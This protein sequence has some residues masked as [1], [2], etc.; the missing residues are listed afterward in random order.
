MINPKSI[1]VLPFVNTSPGTENE[2]FCDGITE[3]IINA[4][5]KIEQLKVTSRTS[6]FFFKGQ[7]RPVAEIG[8]ELGV[9]NLLEG[10]LRVS[11]DRLRISAQL[12][13][14]SD[15]SHF[16]SES[17]DRKLEDIFA[18]QDEI[19]LRIADK[20]REQFG[21][22]DI[23]DQLVQAPTGKVEA[24]RHYL[25]GK[26][27]FNR[28][29]PEDTN[30][31][32]GYFEKALQ[33][34]PDLID[35]HTGLAD[36]YSFLAVAGFAPRE[37]AWAKAI[38]SIQRA[39]AL[40]PQNAP[41]NYLLANQAFFTEANFGQAMWY[42]QQAIASKPTYAEG[43][44]FLA[45]LF[46]LKD[47]LK[48]AG[49]HLRYARSIDPLNPETKFYQAYFLYRSQSFDEAEVL[50]EQLLEA[51]AKNL[52]ALI[53][54][55][56]VFLKTRSFDRAET[57]IV[58]GEPD[59]IMP[60][61]K[62]GLT[63]LLRVMQ[64]EKESYSPLLA[65]L[66][67]NASGDT[68]FQAHAYLFF[69]YC[70]L[71][72]EEQAFSILEKLFQNQSSILL[73]AF[74]DPLADYLRSS[75]RFEQYRQRIYADAAPAATSSRRNSAELSESEADQSL[76]K[77]ADFMAAESPFLDPSLSLRSLAGQLEMHP[78]Q[79]SWLL[80]EKQGKNFN[81]YINAFRV[82]HFKKLLADPQNAY[83]S[84]I[85]L[86]YESGFN[87]KTVFNTVFRKETGMTPREFQ[88]SSSLPD[89]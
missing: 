19:S 26:S 58:H 53:T 30:Q 76:Q 20:L 28:W 34:D 37:I 45:F 80:N 67:T 38:E 54:L 31:A 87:S 39:K 69:V 22:L 75:T 48:K 81:A 46:M 83:I 32:I 6:S 60:D 61:E 50:L 14:V 25:K 66:E 21:H 29:N 49:E 27:L 59:G 88:K 73:L 13:N 79:L 8:R 57:L 43:H 1:A 5:A 16:W 11:G 41:L 4:L 74:G 56:Y 78:N 64:G 71:H 36:A 42:G 51:N 23:A 24:Y 15:D 82:E 65:E 77:L 63:C 18:V 12:I 17:W 85:G 70:T 89:K 2:F 52:P 7:N 44:Q 72:Q 9:A 55:S 3:E 47:D 40:D 86:A 62:L 10:S 68:S 33:I 35:A 84:L